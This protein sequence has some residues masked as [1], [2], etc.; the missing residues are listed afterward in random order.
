MERRIRHDFA[1]Q[2][3]MRTIGA[4]LGDFAP[5][6]VEVHVRVRPALLQEDGSVHPGVVSAIADTAAGYAAMSLLEEDTEGL[7][8]EFKINF[9]TPARGAALVARSR[10]VRAGKRLA[11]SAADVFSLGGGQETC[12]AT[13]LGTFAFK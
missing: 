5:G 12:V 9:V 13:L 2:D 4:T 8:A 3:F 6:F 7:T 1:R 10:L 11:T